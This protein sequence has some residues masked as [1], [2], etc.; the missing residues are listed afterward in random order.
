MAGNGGRENA[1]PVSLFLGRRGVELSYIS[2][3]TGCKVLV[4]RAPRVCA[5]V[6]GDTVEAVKLCRE[7]VLKRIEWLKSKLED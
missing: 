6:S 3:A 7:L 5:V 4:C 1:K 2:K